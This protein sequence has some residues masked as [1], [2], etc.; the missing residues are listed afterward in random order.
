[1]GEACVA[2]PR[3][4]TP[5]PARLALELREV[6]LLLVLLLLL[7][8]LLVLSQLFRAVSPAAA[9]LP[10]LTGGGPG[11]MIM[12]RKPLPPPLLLS[13]V[14]RSASRALLKSSGG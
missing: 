14:S 9:G 4:L 5:L 6:L 10:N 11:R 7:W 2:L 13:R 1:M 3:L 8:L 12:S